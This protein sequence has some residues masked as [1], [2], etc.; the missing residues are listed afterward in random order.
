M[1]GNYNVAIFDAGGNR[2]AAW[3]GAGDPPRNLQAV[4]GRKIKSYPIAADIRDNSELTVYVSAA[5]RFLGTI[6]G[7]PQTQITWPETIL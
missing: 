5:Q 2:Y 6:Q 4:L 1:A 7:K 3:A